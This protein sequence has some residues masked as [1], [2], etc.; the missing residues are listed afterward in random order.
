MTKVEAV[1]RVIR[2]L[3]QEE[4]WSWAYES[5][6]QDGSWNSWVDEEKTIE[7]IIAAI[8]KEFNLCQD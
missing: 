3:K 6:L 8:R 4:D 5:K 2:V 7:S 1:E